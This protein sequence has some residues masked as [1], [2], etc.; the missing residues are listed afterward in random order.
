[1]LVTHCLGFSFPLLRKED[2]SFGCG[3]YLGEQKEW[4]GVWGGYLLF[5]TCSKVAIGSYHQFCV[6][7]EQWGLSLARV[8]SWA[9]QSL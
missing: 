6:L 9:W 3:F 5:N 7:Q 4:E 8:K 1:M 2:V